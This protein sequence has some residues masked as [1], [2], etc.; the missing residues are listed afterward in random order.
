MSDGRSSQARRASLKIQAK[1][2]MEKR[3]GSR[4]ANPKA[5]FESRLAPGPNGCLEWKGF[6]APNGYGRIKFLGKQ[7]DAHRFAWTIYKGKIPVG[8]MVCHHC[9]NKACCNP[10]HLFL[11]VHQDNMDDARTKQLFKS[12]V[13]EAHGMSKLT[14]DDITYAKQKTAKGW[15]QKRIA[16]VLGVDPS[17]VSRIVNGK[18]WAHLC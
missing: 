8:S 4:Y 16:E 2:T 12:P 18:R 3:W 9:D 15:T 5:W 13:G 7:Q 17:A 1:M 10:E 6:C 14:A 11:G